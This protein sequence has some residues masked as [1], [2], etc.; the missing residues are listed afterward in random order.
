MNRKVMSALLLSAA[1]CGGPAFAADLG[2]DWCADLEE[3]VAELE[4]TTARRGNRTVSLQVY[5]QVNTAVLFFDTEVDSDA[6]VVDNQNSNSRFGLQG[7]AKINPNLSAGFLIEVAVGLGAESSEVSEGNDDGTAPGDS[8]VEIRHAYWY[9]SDTRLGK[10]SVGRQSM[11]SDGAMEVD[12][13]GTNVVTLSGL[14]I[15]NELTVGG[16]TFGRIASGNFEFNR[17]NAAR[18]DSPT[19]G[20]FQVG[21]SWGEDDRWDVALRYAGEH[22]GFRVAAAITYGVDTDELPASGIDEKT[23]FGGSASVMHVASGIFVTGIASQRENELIAGGSLDE[24]YW[25]LRAGISKNWFGIGNTIPYAEY[26]FWDN[27]RFDNE[28]TMWGVGIV[29]N[30]DAAAMELYLSYKNLSVDGPQQGEVNGDANLLITG[31]R[32]R[33]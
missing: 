19:F 7:S 5:G 13:G 25:G 16:D 6:Y 10:L 8:R 18:Y 15:G 27:E 30:I 28:A 24:F 23:I 14:N 12:L 31:A 33:F 3:R 4:A 2:G 32:I 21:T 9:L 20:G 29:Q 11:V 22:A 26:N 17:N 1:V